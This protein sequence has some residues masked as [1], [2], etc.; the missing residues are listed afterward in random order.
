MGRILLADDDQDILELVTWRLNKAGH[1]VL[2]ASDGEQALAIA[3]AEKPDLL[4]L[5]VMMPGLDGYE[6]CRRVRA[7]PGFGSI[8]VVLL[9]ARVLDADR[10][11]GHEAG[12][13]DYITK[14]FMLP[15][16][17]RRVEALL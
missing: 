13:T 16:L 17:L 4:L 12:S 5:D 10:Q 8:P 1:E 2:T 9:T 7:T 15:D 14:P 6:V 3:L 11:A